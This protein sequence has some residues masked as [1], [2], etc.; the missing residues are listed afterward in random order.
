MKAIERVRYCYLNTRTV[1][2]PRSNPLQPARCSISNG[3]PPIMSPLIS[4]WIYEYSIYSYFRRERDLFVATAEGTEQWRVESDPSARLV[5]VQRWSTDS[6]A[7]YIALHQNTHVLTS[8]E[9]GTLLARSV[10]QGSVTWQH[11]AHEYS[12]WCV[13]SAGAGAGAGDVFASGGDDCALRVW[14]LRCESAVMANT[15]Q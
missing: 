5:L 15:K 1:P 9:Q 12:A 3:N 14:D 11:R 10:E 6:L 4:V 13:Q 7:L 2:P 8:T